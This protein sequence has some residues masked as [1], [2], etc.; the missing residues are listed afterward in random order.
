MPILRLGKLKTGKGSIL[1]SAQKSQFPEPITLSDNFLLR[2]RILGYN[3]KPS[4]H[5]GNIKAKLSEQGQII[6]E[7]NIHMAAHAYNENLVFVSENL[8]GF[9]SLE[10]LPCA[11]WV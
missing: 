1:Y 10:G 7:N 3:P 6:G 9:E 2:L 11:H 8:P 4:C 5:F